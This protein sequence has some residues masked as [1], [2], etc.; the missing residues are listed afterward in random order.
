LGPQEH[1]LRWGSRNRSD[2]DFAKLLWLHVWSRPVIFIKHF[3]FFGL[4]C[5]LVLLVRTDAVDCLEGS[6][7]KQLIVRLSQHVMLAVAW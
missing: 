6:S 4:F 1:C 2:A 5:R 3:Q 7:P